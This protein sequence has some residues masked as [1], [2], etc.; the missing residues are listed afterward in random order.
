[1]AKIVAAADAPNDDEFDQQ[2]E[3]LEK[4][5]LVW[6]DAGKDRDTVDR[7]AQSELRTIINYLKI[8]E[9]VDDC[10]NFLEQA[11]HHY[12]V[13]IVSGQLGRKIVPIIHDL[14]QVTAIYVYCIDKPRNEQWTREFQKV[15]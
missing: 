15:R 3:N 13:L 14:H 11:E 8:F 12:I 7:H 5:S 6:L 4:F 10:Q 2:Y 9:N 1:M